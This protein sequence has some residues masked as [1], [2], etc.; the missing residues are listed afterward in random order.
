M[1]PL[2]DAEGRVDIQIRDID[3]TVVGNP[4]HDLVRLGLS[5]ASA[6]RGS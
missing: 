3:Q 6:A 5:L 1:G 2:A 4:T